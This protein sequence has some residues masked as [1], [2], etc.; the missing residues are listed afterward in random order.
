MLD[1]RAKS[2]KRSPVIFKYCKFLKFL[3]IDFLFLTFVRNCVLDINISGIS[4]QILYNPLQCLTSYLFSMQMNFV[5]DLGSVSKINL[6]HWNILGEKTMHTLFFTRTIYSNIVCR[7]VVL[8]C[9]INSLWLRQNALRTKEYERLF[10][11][12][13]KYIYLLHVAKI[14]L[15]K[16]DL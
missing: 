6:L 13:Q 14:N 4:Y 12:P 9:Y 8:L 7:M 3:V 5:I 10:Y 15:L 16:I 2:L 1:K 11:R